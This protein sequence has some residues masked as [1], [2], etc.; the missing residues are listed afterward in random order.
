MAKQQGIHID[1][2]KRWSL[3][4]TIAFSYISRHVF[5]CVGDIKED[6]TG[7]TVVVARNP[8][9]Q[10]LFPEQ[11]IPGNRYTDEDIF[12]LCFGPEQQPLE[13]KSLEKELSTYKIATKL[14]KSRNE[15]LMAEGFINGW[16]KADADAKDTYENYYGKTH[17]RILRFLDMI[18]DITQNSKQGARNSAN[19]FQSGFTRAQIL[20]L[21][22]VLESWESSKW[23]AIRKEKYFYLDRSA[24]EVVETALDLFTRSG[25]ERRHL[26]KLWKDRQKIAAEEIFKREIQEKKQSIEECLKS[27]RTSLNAYLQAKPRNKQEQKAQLRLLRNL[28]RV[29]Y[30]IEDVIIA[31]AMEFDDNPIKKKSEIS[32]QRFEDSIN[33]SLQK[34]L[35]NNSKN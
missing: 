7:E 18:L 1:S 20:F 26:R 5:S 33:K 9:V 4:D 17:D 27:I 6:S 21:S 24:M 34:K 14:N 10:K 25:Y 11:Y 23:D 35:G 13:E 3:A 8:W 19:R 15:L 12:E 2:E 31:K 30:T 28:G 29:L 22:S 32:I 16:G